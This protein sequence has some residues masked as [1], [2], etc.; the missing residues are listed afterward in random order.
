MRSAPSTTPSLTRRPRRVRVGSGRG[1]AHSASPFSYSLS[2]G[3]ERPPS[4]AVTNNEKTGRSRI[5]GIKVSASGCLVSSPISAGQR[6]KEGLHGRAGLW[7][8]AFPEQVADTF[9][10]QQQ[11]SA[12]G[13]SHALPESASIS[14]RL[15]GM[16]A[17][18]T[19]TPS[20]VHTT[21]SSMRMP[22]KPRP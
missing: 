2:F 7:A 8:D 13:G 14:A 15:L 20:S 11:G 10:E 16:E 17:V 1:F 4:V 6:V 12:C 21:S 18:S 5:T 19:S 9:P 3:Q 22:P